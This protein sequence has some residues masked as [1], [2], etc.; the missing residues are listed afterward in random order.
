MLWIMLF[1]FRNI[2]N[3][4]SI[5]SFKNYYRCCNRLVLYPGIIRLVFRIFVVRNCLIQFFELFRK[6][7]FV[8]NNSFFTKTCQKCLVFFFWL[9]LYL[10]PCFTQLFTMN[11][12]PAFR[13]RHI[14]FWFSNSSIMRSKSTLCISSFTRDLML[15][16][17]P[18]LT[19][20]RR[21]H[22]LS[23]RCTT[24]RSGFSSHS[25]AHKPT[26][27]Q[28]KFSITRHPSMIDC[29]INEWLIMVNSQNGSKFVLVL[30]T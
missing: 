25:A 29:F 1:N 19:H 30:K 15:T 28:I 16:T 14:S 17:F 23:R 8:S 27:K 2:S 18:F 7:L 11:P 24:F 12:N 10:L 4:F 6:V 22:C 3:T 26:I 13:A 21:H 20:V 5:I 9:K